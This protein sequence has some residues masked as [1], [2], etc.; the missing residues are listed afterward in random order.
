MQL[1]MLQG[2]ASVAACITGYN[3]VFGT[4]SSHV[5]GK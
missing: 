5:S 4:A 2:C 1:N 3:T